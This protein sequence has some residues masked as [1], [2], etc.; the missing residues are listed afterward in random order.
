MKP[1]HVLI[2]AAC[3]V[4][5]TIDGFD[6]SVM[7]FLVPYLPDSMVAA[8]AQRGLILSIGIMGMGEG[9]LLL[10][11]LADRIGRK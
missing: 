9:A 8:E 10:G 4:V 2:I 7:G 5:L 6:V 3:F 1:A 11:S